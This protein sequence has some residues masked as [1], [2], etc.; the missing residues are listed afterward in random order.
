[1]LSLFLLVVTFL[2]EILRAAFDRPFGLLGQISL[3]TFR[4]LTPARMFS[5]EDMS[6]LRVLFA[7]VIVLLLTESFLLAGSIT[8]LSWPVSSFNLLILELVSTADAA[9]FL[10]VLLTN[11]LMVWSS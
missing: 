6:R 5:D 1:M 3:S 4:L 7:R 10:A 9:S 11:E 8:V 2:L